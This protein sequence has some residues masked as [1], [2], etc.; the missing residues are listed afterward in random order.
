MYDD[1][2]T[3]EEENA[4]YLRQNPAV[5]GGL[6]EEWVRVCCDWDKIPHPSHEEWNKLRANWCNNKAPIESKNELRKMRGI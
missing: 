3:P 5:E 2:L 4:A 6:W 1:E